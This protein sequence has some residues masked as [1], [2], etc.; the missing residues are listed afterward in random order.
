[1][2]T[3]AEQRAADLASAAWTLDNLRGH[4]EGGGLLLVSATYGSGATDY[5]RATAV[6]ANPIT[7][8]QTVWNL[9]WAMAKMFGYSSRDRHGYWHLALGGGGYSKPYELA[10]SLA[11]YYGLDD[12][13]YELV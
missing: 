5:F 10:R 7:G 8:A 11:R 6:V 3:K 4:F 1:M 2:T 9:T 13:R 12:L